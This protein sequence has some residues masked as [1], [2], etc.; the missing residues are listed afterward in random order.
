[1]LDSFNTGSNMETIEVKGQFEFMGKMIPCIYGGFGNGRKCI[2]DITVA[3][4]HNQPIREIRR[5][6]S[7]NR[8]R[9]HEGIDYVDLKKSVGVD[10]T[11]AELKHTYSGTGV[12]GSHTCL[13]LLELIGYTSQMIAQST[14]AFLFSERGY[15]KF[16]RLLNTDLAWDIHDKLLD[17]YFSMREEKVNSIISEEIK[18]LPYENQSPMDRITYYPSSPDSVMLLEPE[19]VITENTSITPGADDFR[20]EVQEICRSIMKYNPCMRTYRAVLFYIYKTLT[21]YNDQNNDV[22]WFAER[23]QFEKETGCKVESNLGMLANM[24]IYDPARRK[25]M[26]YLKSY[27]EILI[28]KKI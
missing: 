11:Y 8:K 4:L 28:N 3:E 7:K 14:H 24:S 25:F 15:A 9:F 18:S 21:D 17:N 10:H 23:H 16:I 19:F 26:S 6:I 22:D 5:R 13:Q 2:S 1:M 12:A 27:N 20:K